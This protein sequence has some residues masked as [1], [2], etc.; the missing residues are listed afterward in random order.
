MVV[1]GE[2]TTLK[3]LEESNGIIIAEMPI[4]VY[5]VESINEKARNFL[6]LITSINGVECAFFLQISEIL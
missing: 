5:I 4:N 2:V 3:S 1:G 6:L